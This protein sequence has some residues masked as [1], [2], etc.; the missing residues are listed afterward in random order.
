[1]T[2][3]TSADGIEWTEY[4]TR[5]A[6]QARSGGWCEYCGAKATEMHHRI[7]R[8]QGGGWHPSNIVHLCSNCHR[9]ATHYPLWAKAVGLS[10]YPY[11]DGLPTD[12][13][14]LRIRRKDRGL[15]WLTDELI[16]KAGV[17]A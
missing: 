12:T 2:T 11:T 14:K 16:A 10:V 3:A 1:M 15:L 4:Y 9:K 6:V 8:S 17:K 7:N 13:T 5:P